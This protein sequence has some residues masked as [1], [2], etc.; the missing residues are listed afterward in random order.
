VVGVVGDAYVPALRLLR[1]GYVA[2]TLTVIVS[3]RLSFARPLLAGLRVG[4]V[5]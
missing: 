3:A 1:C 5:L 4:I 2:R